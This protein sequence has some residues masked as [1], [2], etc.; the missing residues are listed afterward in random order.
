MDNNTNTVAIKANETEILIPA[1][2]EMTSKAVEGGKSQPIINVKKFSEKELAIA[3]KMAAGLNFDDGMALM[4]FGA[5]PQRKMTSYLEP[6]LKGIRAKDAGIAGDYVISL[7]KGMNMLKIKDYHEKVSKSGGIF[8]AAALFNIIKVFY[9][10][11]QK[12]EKLINQIKAQMAED[13]IT[14]EKAYQQFD[15][16]VRQTLEFQDEMAIAIIAGEVALI[17]MNTEKDRLVKVGDETRDAQAIAEANDFIARLDSFDTRVIDMKIAYYDAMASVPQLRAAQTAEKLQINNLIRTE[18]TDLPAF[19]EAIATVA[20]MTRV[21]KIM[22]RNLKFQTAR[23]DLQVGAAKL[24]GETLL[25]SL[26]A[27]GKDVVDRVNQA[28]ARAELIMEYAEKADEKRKENRLLRNEA[29][30]AIADAASKLKVRMNDL[31]LNSMS[32]TP[33]V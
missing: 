9:K 20:T 1:T 8:N 27:E 25:K 33:K 6:L 3:S 2:I 23:A 30:D 7:T 32:E 12:V 26:D 10:R 28:I 29:A 14:L 17:R 18:L 21:A 15:A 16:L 11:Q 31:N 13:R 22:K 4:T 5:G 24:T 19:M